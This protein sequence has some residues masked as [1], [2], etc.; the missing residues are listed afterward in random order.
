MLT[1][2]KTPQC[3]YCGLV[4]KYLDSRG[5]KYKEVDLE[6]HPEIRQDLIHKTGAMTVPITSDGKEYVVG[7]NPGKLAKLVAAQ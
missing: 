4:K 5:A 2:Y 1:V 6:A 7:W 3:A